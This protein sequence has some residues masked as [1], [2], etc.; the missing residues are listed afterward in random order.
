MSKFERFKKLYG[1]EVMAM[2]KWNKWKKMKLIG[3]KDESEAIG[4]EVENPFI[5]ADLDDKLTYWAYDVKEVD[6]G[7][8]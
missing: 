2:W 1:Q 7:S 8:D 6:D 3:F 4:R 5:V